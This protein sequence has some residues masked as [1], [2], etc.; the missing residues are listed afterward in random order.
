VAHADAQARSANV[1]ILLLLL[2]RDQHS[3]IFTEVEL[4]LKG[5]SQ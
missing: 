5:V 4:L 1:D 2:E 3:V